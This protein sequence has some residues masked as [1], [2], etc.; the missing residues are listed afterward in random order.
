[1]ACFDL[2]PCSQTHPARA[3]LKSCFTCARGHPRGYSLYLLLFERFVGLTLAA[4]A[5]AERNP[6]GNYN[7]TL[8]DCVIR[9]IKISFVRPLEESSCILLIFVVLKPNAPAN[10]TLCCL[11]FLCIC[12]GFKSIGFLTI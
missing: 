5:D 2:E 8:I 6:Y 3:P 11:N 9:N 7:G 4:A 12:D 10:G 1:M